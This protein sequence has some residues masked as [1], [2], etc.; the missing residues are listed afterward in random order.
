[1]SDHAADID[2]QVKIYLMVF[3]AL[4]LLTITTVA[5]WY[6][7]ELGV[8]ATIAVALFIASIKGSLVACFF[9]HMIDERKL[10]HWVLLGSAG[11]GCSVCLLVG[12]ILHRD[13]GSSAARGRGVH[14]R[15]RLRA[16]GG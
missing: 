12:H 1:M 9:M 2:R 5:A 8:G 4:M 10:I 6:Y 14:A 15:S 13:T 3:F 11:S 7:L 16:S